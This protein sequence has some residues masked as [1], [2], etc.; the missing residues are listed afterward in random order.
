VR[1]R[2]QRNSGTWDLIEI[3]RT[4]FSSDEAYNNAIDF[5][6]ERGAIDEDE[7][8]ACMSKEQEV[9]P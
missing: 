6:Y 7:Y 3:R 8:R 9:K 5:H 2:I 1:L 4:N